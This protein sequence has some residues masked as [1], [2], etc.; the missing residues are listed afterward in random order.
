MK[1]N[2]KFPLSPW[3]PVENM[4]GF[5]KEIGLFFLYFL[6]INIYIIYYI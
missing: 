5:I 6:F 3:F 2:E 4:Q 1:N